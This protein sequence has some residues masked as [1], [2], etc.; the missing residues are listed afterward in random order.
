[1][2]A[3]SCGDSGE[4]TAGDTDRGNRHTIV[5]SRR[6]ANERELVEPVKGVL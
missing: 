5:A 1:M 3:L 6:T 4:A 2:V